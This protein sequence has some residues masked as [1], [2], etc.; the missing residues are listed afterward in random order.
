MPPPLVAVALLSRFKPIKD[1]S[2]YKRPVMLQ[3]AF[4]MIPSHQPIHSV[5]P[6]LNMGGLPSHHIVAKPTYD[7][8]SIS[9]SH[10]FRPTTRLPIACLITIDS[11]AYLNKQSH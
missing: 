11:S 8:K 10:V 5:T 4:L 3:A 6:P 9:V 2:Q 1:E 7:V